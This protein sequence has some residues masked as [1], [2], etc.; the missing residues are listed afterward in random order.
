[1]NDTKVSRLLDVLK[2]RVPV[3]RSEECGGGRVD[4]AAGNRL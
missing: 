4:T 2:P 1:M 3:L